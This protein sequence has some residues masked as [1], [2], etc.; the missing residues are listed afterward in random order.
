MEHGTRVHLLL[1]HLPQVPRASWATTAESLLQNEVPDPAARRAIREEAEKV[2]TAPALVALFA[3]SALTE[4]EI[5]APLPALGRQMMG[6]IDRL[7]VTESE[8]LAV[9]FKTNAVV[10]DRPEHTPKGLLR[11]M[12]AYLVALEQIYPGRTVRVALVWTRTAQRM[13]L[14]G[15]LVREA[16]AHADVSP[17]QA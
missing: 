5:T 13:D 1:E 9:D 14:P 15:E 17:A 7:V 16:L 8:V 10:P 11:Q 6:T 2:L 12:G 3:P 4:V